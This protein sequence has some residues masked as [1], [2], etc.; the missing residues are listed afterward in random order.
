MQGLAKEYQIP[1]TKDFLGSALS[2][3][4]GSDVTQ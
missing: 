2:Q 1:N 3:L 4:C